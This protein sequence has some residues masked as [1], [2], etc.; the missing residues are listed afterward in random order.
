[1]FHREER[2]IVIKR[3]YIT[4]EQEQKLREILATFNLPPLECAVIESDW[5]EYEEVWGMIE[6]RVS[7]EALYK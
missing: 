7:V 4:E 2:Y 1:M 6:T 3:K 5:P